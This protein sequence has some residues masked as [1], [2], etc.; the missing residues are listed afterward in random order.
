MSFIPVSELTAER[1]PPDRFSLWALGFRPFFLGAA[2]HA[3]LAMA[4]WLASA[5]SH[6][7]LPSTL[8]NYFWHAHEMLFGFTAAVVTGFLLTATRNWT[9]VDTLSGRPLAAL[10]TLWALPRLLHFGAWL[11]A[12]ALAALDC[13][14]LLL[15]TL[16]VAHPL[17]RARHTKSYVF[18]VLLGLLTLADALSYWALLDPHRAALLPPAERLA[19][20]AVLAVLILMGGRVIPFFTERGLQVTLRQ[21]PL[22]ALA[23]RASLWSLFALLAVDLLWGDRRAVAV[24][25]LLTGL[26]NALRAGCWYHPRI[27]RVPLVWVLHTG[28]AW[29]AAGF[30]LHAAAT[31]GWIPLPTGLHGYT[32]GAIGVLTLGMMARV[33]LG[34]TGRPLQVGRA[35]T[36]AFALANLAAALRVVP[37]LLDPTHQAL[38]LTG[39][40]LAWIAA[41]GLFSGVYAPILWRAR[42]DGLPG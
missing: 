2:L 27:W 13:G 23:E 36:L 14:F 26:L 32:A 11:P 9:G 33:S 22:R 38:W 12:G 39:S 28:Y 5:L 37:W 25:A 17:V 40:A 15:A 35:V 30:L 6:Y 21:G 3:V 34:H 1:I 7:G 42:A 16:A 41:F 31:L 29:L 24:L 20:Y 19:L 10:F 8:G 4:L 18:I